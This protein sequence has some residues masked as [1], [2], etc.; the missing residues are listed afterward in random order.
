MLL[1][2][3]YQKKC[4]L[5]YICNL[6]LLEIAI[7]LVLSASVQ[8]RRLFYVIHDDDDVVELKRGFSLRDSAGW[9]WVAIG[10][11]EDGRFCVVPNPPEHLQDILLIEDEI[12]RSAAWDA[13]C[14]A[15]RKIEE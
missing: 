3:P 1:V 4:G 9:F 5:A 14:A 10:F 2:R 11:D 15:Q 12:P 6:Y 13:F 8:L 7:K